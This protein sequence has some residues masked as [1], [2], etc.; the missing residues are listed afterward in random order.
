MDDNLKVLGYIALL[1]CVY[2]GAIYIVLRFGRVGSGD[3]SA[4]CSQCTGLKYKT[5]D[6][7]KEE[8]K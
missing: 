2:V 4:E 7:C 5:C 8:T 3:P 6:E 1:M